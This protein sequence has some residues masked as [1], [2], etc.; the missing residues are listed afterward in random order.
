[1]LSRSE[2]VERLADAARRHGLDADPETLMAV[3]LT[4]F[5]PRVH[6]TG[7]ER[8]FLIESDVPTD[9]FDSVTQAL[10]HA[11]LLARAEATS[12]AAAPVLSAAQAAELLGVNV[13]TV[14]RRARDR[15]LYAVPREKPGRRNALGFPA[16]QFVG[17]RG[18]PGLHAVLDQVL[19][20]GQGLGSMHPLSLEGL[21]TTP[22]EE[23]D[24]RTPVEWLASGGDPQAVVSLVESAAYR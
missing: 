5:A 11:S 6:M 10:A 9:S 22:Q 23:L 4:A 8:Q 17:G 12:A 21:M 18:L 3:I 19:A 15:T 1:M 20:H 16:W 7:Q 14:H 24:G 2:A 13:R